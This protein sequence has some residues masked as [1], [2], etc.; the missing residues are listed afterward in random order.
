M[1]NNY[2]HLTNFLETQSVKSLFIIFLAV[3]T[4]Y[5]IAL[6]YSIQNPDVLLTRDSRE[7]LAA[8]ENLRTHGFLYA[9]NPD[10]SFDP[11]LYSRRPPGYPLLILMAKLFWK[12]NHAIIIL[13]LFMIIL[14]VFLIWKISDIVKIPL[15][16]K[17]SIIII[18][19]LYPSQIIY[20]FTIM[21]EILFQTLLLLSLISFL[22]FL[23]KKKIRYVWYY[24]LCLS[25][26]V[27]T[28]PVL[29]YFWIPNLLFHV[30]LALKYRRKAVILMPLILLFTVISWSIRNY[31]VTGYYHFSSIKSFNLLYYNTYP[32]LLNKY[33]EAQADQFLKELE[34]QN[35]QADFAQKYRNIEKA[36]YQQLARDPVSYAL[37]HLRGSV[38]LFIDPGRYDLYHFLRLEK[39]VGFLSYVSRYGFRGIFIMLRELPVAAILYL[40]LMLLF[41]MIILISL[42]VFTFMP[43]IKPVFK[44]MFLLIIIYIAVMT[45]PVGASRHR[46]PVLPY[47]V[48]TIA[49]SIP[50]IPGRERFQNKE[51]SEKNGNSGGEEQ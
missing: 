13:H 40:I 5:S 6:I 24:N 36:C 22:K 9:G 8:A 33:G 31:Y 12:N 35:A 26:A 45:G 17:Y 1:I 39:R 46:I 49:F 30:W 43:G 47:L 2:I 44:L 25:A 14:N 20:T 7:Y 48:L 51:R 28:K 42:I 11:A 15:I 16:W 41:N 50:S 32:F 10:E 18:F 29:V 23:E 3:I 34:S 19:L 27:L 37:F 4:V 38:F 21:S